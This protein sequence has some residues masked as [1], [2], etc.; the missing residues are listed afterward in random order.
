MPSPS[1]AIARATPYATPDIDPRDYIPPVPVGK[2]VIVSGENLAKKIQQAQDDDSVTSVRVEGGGSITIPVI[3]RKHTA[4]DSST[5]ACDV[6]DATGFIP[7]VSVTDYGCFLVSDGVLVEGTWRP[8]QALVDY[9]EKGDGRNRF[10]PY[11]LKVQALT[12]EQLAGEGTTILE[13]T[14]TNG[15]LPSITVFQ[16]KGDACCSHA[17]KAE[18]VAILGFRIKGRQQTPDGGVR[19]TVQFGNCHH[20]LAQYV[21]LE[22]TG[23]IGISFGGSASQ[24]TTVGGTFGGNFSNDSVMYRNVMSGVSAANMATLNAENIFTFENYVRRP[25]HHD[26][27]FGGGVCG[28]DHETNSNEDHTRNIWVYNNLFD[29]EGANRDGAGS[30]VCLQDPY[31]GPNRGK[32]VAA[33]NV[34]IGGRDD[35]VHRFMS[36][37][38]YLV[39]LKGCEVVNNYVFR[40]GQNALQ[41]YALNGCLVQDNDFEHTGGGGG[42]TINLDGVVN[43]TFRRN[44][45]RDRPGLAISSAAGIIESCG[46]GN[47]YEDNRAMGEPRKDCPPAAPRAERPK[48]V[49]PV[50]SRTRIP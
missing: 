46:S 30:A 26:P 5:Y 8:P 36:N 25:G 35:R 38:I 12:A 22:D 34:A 43:S 32:V 3:L 50:G 44:N 14:Y 7:G 16:T 6:T 24:V 2:T 49:Y 48:K 10:D 20:C 47:T 13:S 31:V 23:S 41:G 42:V 45:Y 9:W 33:N 15:G 19:S 40:T 37:G 4:F 21:Y 29:Y 39:G 11:L 17:D 1:P 28:Y 27:L 18:N